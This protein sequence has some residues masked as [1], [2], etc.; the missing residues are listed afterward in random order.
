MLDTISKLEHFL[1]MEMSGE[2]LKCHLEINSFSSSILP[3]ASIHVTW[4]FPEISLANLIVMGIRMGME[5]YKKQNRI[6]TEND[7]ICDFATSLKLL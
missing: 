5:M 6:T 4:I 3:S 7:L 2:I 1:S